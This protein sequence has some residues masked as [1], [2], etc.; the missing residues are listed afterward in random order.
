MAVRIHPQSKY[1][2]LRQKMY[3]WYSWVISDSQVRCQ[4]AKKEK[5]A[6]K[7]KDIYKILKDLEYDVTR[8]R[9]WA[10]KEIESMEKDV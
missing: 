3:I 5:D 2:M 9:E 7:I 8:Y 10:G 1:L 6:G 4:D